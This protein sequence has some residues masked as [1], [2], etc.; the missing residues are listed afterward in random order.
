MRSSRRRVRSSRVT[1]ALLADVEAARLAASCASYAPNTPSPSQ[2]PAELELEPLAVVADPDHESG[3]VVIMGNQQTVY[4]GKI[5]AS[6]AAKF[7]G[8][9]DR[10]TRAECPNDGIKPIANRSL[11]VTHE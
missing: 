5:K 9:K 7:L 1:R 10:V 4:V 3:F 2:S 8:L 6:Q 11:Y